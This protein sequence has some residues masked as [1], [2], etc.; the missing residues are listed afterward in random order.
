MPH[1]VKRYSF[2]CGSPNS[3]GCSSRV[4]SIREIRA[5]IDGSRTVDQNVGFLLEKTTTGVRFD[6]QVVI[7]RRSLK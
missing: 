1:G 3:Y 7:H 5:S 4:A 2:R 6:D